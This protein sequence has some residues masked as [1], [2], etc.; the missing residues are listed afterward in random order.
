MQER[1]RAINLSISN[2]LRYADLEETSDLGRVLGRG[3][4]CLKKNSKNFGHPYF[5]SG[6]S[7]PL[8]QDILVNGMKNST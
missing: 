3:Q 6:L 7:P 2:N 1:M 4:G 8:K 5:C